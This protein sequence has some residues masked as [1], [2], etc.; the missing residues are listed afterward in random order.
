MSASK[1]ARF[2]ERQ[3]SQEKA[4]RLGLSGPAVVARHDFIEARATRGAARILYLLAQG[5]HE[6]AEAQINLPNWGVE[7]EGQTPA[8]LSATDTREGSV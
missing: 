3:A 8:C 1:I 5:R 2:R 6:E 7:E 4:A